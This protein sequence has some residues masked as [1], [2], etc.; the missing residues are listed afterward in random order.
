MYDLIA[1]VVV[2]GIIFLV[3]QYGPLIKLREKNR[4]LKEELDRDVEVTRIL[5]H[6]GTCLTQMRLRG[7]PIIDIINLTKNTLDAIGESD[8]V[9]V[10]SLR[11]SLKGLEETHVRRETYIKEALT[12]FEDITDGK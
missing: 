6:Y 1:T 10:I 5:R 3:L 11:E 7:A 4:R 12:E 2:I 9:H 8:D